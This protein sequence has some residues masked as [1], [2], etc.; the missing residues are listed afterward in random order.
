MRFVK[1]KKKETKK[2][3]TKRS[4][5]LSKVIV[6]ESTFLDENG[7]SIIQQND[8]EQASILEKGV[9]TIIVVSDI[10]AGCQ[11]ALCPPKGVKLDGGGT[12]VPTSES[13]KLWQ[14]NTEGELELLYQSD[15]YLSDFELVEDGS[16]RYFYIATGNHK[17]KKY[18]V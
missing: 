18:G 5:K 8:I 13:G 15:R 14:L 16:V 6:P 12:Y 10:H 2:I 7:N 9:R 3:E 4:K 1:T 11:Y 17:T